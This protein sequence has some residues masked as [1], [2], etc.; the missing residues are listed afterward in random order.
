MDLLI[1]D[2][3]DVDPTP[4]YQSTGIHRDAALEDSR[5]L[6]TTKIKVPR[7]ALIT[8]RAFFRLKA[9]FSA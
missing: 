4:A 5:L 7:L 6:E 9:L 3:N 8:V 1:A 2:L